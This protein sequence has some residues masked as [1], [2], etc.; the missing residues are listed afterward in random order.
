MGPKYP[1]GTVGFT[2][3]EE[4]LRPHTPPRLCTP[5]SYKI[6]RLSNK[7]TKVLF[8]KWLKTCTT[9][10]FKNSLPPENPS[11]DLLINI[12]MKIYI[13][14]QDI[15][16][17]FFSSRATPGPS[18]SMILFLKLDIWD[19]TWKSTVF[20]FITTIYA[21]ST[22]NTL[23]DLWRPS[24]LRLHAKFIFVPP[25][26][27]KTPFLKKY[28]YFFNYVQVNYSIICTLPYYKC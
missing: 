1:L 17:Y 19:T 28:W 27:L 15:Y 2:D 3:P 8:K 5:L 10:F 25:P 13:I 20:Y 24:S 22:A 11:K 26:P 21:C 7:I 12:C 4:K 14:K 6:T 23:K 9:N 16:I 18:A